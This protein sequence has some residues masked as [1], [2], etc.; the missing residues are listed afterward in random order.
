MRTVGLRV[1][2]D[3][4]TGTRD[5]LPA[6][7]SLLDRHGIRATFF[8]SVGPDNMG[9][10]LWRML[11]PDFFRKMLRSNAPSLYGPR[12]LLAGT[13]WP[14]RRI[15]AGAGN[16]MRRCS[17]VGHEVGLH[18]WDHHA[19]QKHMPDW[20]VGE[21]RRQTAL[22]LEA[23]QDVLGSAVHCSAAP[24]WRAD[25]KVVEAK[26]PFAFTYN[27]DCR[28]ERPFRP[29]LADGSPGTSQVPV[30]LP[31]FDEV[32]GREVRED[33]FNGYILNAVHTCRGVPVYTIHAEV[34]GVSR[35]ALFADLLEKAGRQSIRFCPLRDLLPSDPSELP[36]GD[37]ELRPF[38]GR[39][40]TLGVQ[41]A[42]EGNREF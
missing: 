34:E 21:L 1:D 39:E 42:H 3:T 2:A 9:R 35:A 26:E 24:G 13:A 4:Y 22:G 5:G 33:G 8:F 38:P 32:I 20:S 18:A 16:V 36:C 19:W 30:S 17:E 23:L 11:R 25:R 40:G 6:L 10:H 29:K 15:A 27:S 14:G 41:T 37:I 31:T 12:I 7:L 28:G